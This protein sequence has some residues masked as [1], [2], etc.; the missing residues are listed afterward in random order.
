MTTINKLSATDALAASDQF[1][2]YD[3]SNG[4]ARRAALSLIK[5]FILANFVENLEQST[6]TIV[7]GDLVPLYDLS[8]NQSY[9]F[10]VDLLRNFIRENIFGGMTVGSDVA[11]TDLLTIYDTSAGAVRSV[12]GTLLRNFVRDNVFGG[13]T[14]GTALADADLITIYDDSAAAVRSLTAALLADYT[15]KKYFSMQYASPSASGFSV[16]ITNSAANTHLILTPTA[17]F[18]AGT[19]VLPAIANVVDKQEILVNCTQ[20]VVSLTVDGNGAGAVTGE[21]SSLGADDFF[22]LKYDATTDAWY[23]V[24]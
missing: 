18:A 7:S 14:A 4:D 10:D 21:P 1:P 20:Q 2:L 6:N 13:M 11:L 15:Q 17:G 23:R 24:G 9:K 19:I 12:T 22:R 8:A 3:E 16:A 5:S